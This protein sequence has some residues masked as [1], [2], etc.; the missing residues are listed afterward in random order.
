M[1]NGVLPGND[2]IADFTSGADKIDLSAFGITMTDVKATTANGTT[3]LAIDTNHD[4]TSDFTI[5]LAGAAAPV[6]GD[7]LF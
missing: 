5:T 2:T 4:G 3:T 6:V 7:Y 1:F